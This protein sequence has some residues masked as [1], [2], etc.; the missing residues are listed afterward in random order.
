MTETRDKIVIESTTQGVDQSTDKLKGLAKAYDGVSVA[1]EQTEKSTVSVENKF[2][3]LE[4]RFG[5]ASGQAAQLAKVQKDVNLAVAQNP[6]LQERAKGL[7]PA[8]IADALFDV[9]GDFLASH[10][11]Y[12]ALLDLPGDD[13]WRRQMRAKRRAQIAALFARAEPPLP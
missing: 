1:S 6:A 7:A 5:T 9:L 3:G 2:G 8:A 11:A 4:K 13:G 10:P 12:S